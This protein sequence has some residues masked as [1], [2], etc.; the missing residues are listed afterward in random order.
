M[1]YYTNKALDPN[2]KKKYTRAELKNYKVSRS[3]LNNDAGIKLERRISQDGTKKFFIA[4]ITPGGLVDRHLPDL[5]VGD[6]IIEINGIEMEEFPGLYQVHE[7]IKKEY[8][9][10]FSL[11]KEEKEKKWLHA[12]KKEY[13][14]QLDKP[15]YEEEFRPEST[16]Y[17]APKP[18]SKLPAI[19]S[20]KKKS[21]APQGQV[22]ATTTVDGVTKQIANTSI[23][24]SQAPMTAAKQHAFAQPDNYEQSVSSYHPANEPEKMSKPAEGSGPQGQ[25]KAFKGW[26]PVAKQHESHTSSKK[27]QV[28]KEVQDEW[29]EEGNLT[30]TTIEHIIQ[31]GWTSS[32]KKKTIQ[33]IPAA[34]AAKYR[35]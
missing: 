11:L 2:R 23:A 21:A 34:E 29:D 15:Q 19:F 16:S 24:R 28:R 30:R 12:P 33:K 10:T 8:D 17:P 5:E 32:K 13:A 1:E 22:T 26:S 18:K 3:N 27:E 4:S 7:L 6:R 9:I 20:R 25:K 35:K 14:G 31:P